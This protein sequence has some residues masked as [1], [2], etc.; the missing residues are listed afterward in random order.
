MARVLV[1]EKLA[2]SGLDQLR[3]AGHDVDVQLGL[4]DEQLLE[5]V[6]GAAALIVRSATQV[7][8]EVLA[9]GRDLVIVGRAGV[10]VDNVDVAAATS[11]GVMVANAPGSNALS[12]AEHT[13]AM[14]LAQARNVPQADAA[15]KAGRWEKSKWGGVE[16]YGKTLGVIGLGRIGTLV[17]Q[18]SLA[19]GMQILVWDPWLAPERARQLGVEQVELDD[20]ISRADFATIHLLKTPES[21]DLIDDALLAKAKPGLRIVNCGR[22]GIIDEGALLRALQDGRIGGAALDVFD[23]E[24]NTDS[25]LFELPNVVATPH[26]S[27]STPEA[28]DKAGVMIAEQ[29]ALALAGKFVPFAVNVQ[30]SEAPEDVQPYLGL[31][32]RL[33]ALFCGLNGGV[34]SLLEVE[35]QGQLADYDTRILTLSVLKGLFSGSSDAVTYVNAP[36]LAEQAGVEVKEVKTTASHDFVNLVTLRGGDHAIGGTLTGV[37][38][39]PRVV[40]LDDHTVELPPAAHLLVVRNDDRPGMIGLVT[41][42]L[43]AAGVNI[44]DLHLGRSATG[45]MA[46]QVLA[47]DQPA[48]QSLVEQLRATEGIASVTAL[49]S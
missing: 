39:E 22:G 4:S 28:Q 10:G 12:T 14:L 21:V 35:Y 38:G 43:G 40:M 37:K 5:V 36:Q 6:P 42:S 25:P 3:A 8:A 23:A 26:L 19:F 9:A 48:P 45:A 17:A 34:P 41:S 31:A 32:E 33:G 13:M 20:L 18:R 24:P 15:L 16:L 30:A 1:T 46:L 2:E 29:V 27:A 49:S 7:T 44:S 47:L 11:R